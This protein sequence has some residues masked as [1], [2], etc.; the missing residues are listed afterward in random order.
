[1]SATERDTATRG[2]LSRGCSGAS[3]S[4]TAAGVPESRALERLRDSAGESAGPPP[5]SAAGGDPWNSPVRPT[6]AHRRKLLTHRLS[7]S[8]RDARARRGAY[9]QQAG[10]VASDVQAVDDARQPELRDDDLPP[11]TRTTT[12]VL[13]RRRDERTGSS[14]TWRFPSVL[15]TRGRRSTLHS[16]RRPAEGSWPADEAIRNGSR[17]ASAGDDARVSA[18]AVLPCYRRDTARV[19]RLRDG[20]AGVGLPNDPVGAEPLLAAVSPPVE[21]S[22][23]HSSSIP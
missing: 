12:R 3:L 21:T 10:R 4:G 2:L 1:M 17:H 14:Q 11:R 22:V 7:G 9:G 20:A 23:R 19:G 18:L 5:L 16:G 15:G 8:C 13:S 6:R